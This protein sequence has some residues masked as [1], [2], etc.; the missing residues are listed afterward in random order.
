MCVP[1]TE[2]EENKQ[3]SDLNGD[4][5]PNE[6]APKEH[7]PLLAPITPC[8]TPTGAPTKSKANHR[9]RQNTPKK[10]SK[11]AKTIIY[12]QN[13]QGGKDPLKLEYITETMKERG[14]DIYLLQETWLEGNFTRDIGEGCLLIH[15]G[16]EEATCNRGTGGVGI[17]LS[18]RA[19]EA[20]NKAGNPPPTYGGVFKRRQLDS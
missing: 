10:R 17:I 12:S 13:I 15:H 16:L 4:T 5:R 6:I 11:D 1:T 8:R 9:N 3:T 7:R 19:K 14:I 2:N 20:W 18:K